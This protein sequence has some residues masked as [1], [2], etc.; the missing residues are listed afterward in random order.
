MSN[1]SHAN[2]ARVIHFRA[3]NSPRENSLTVLSKDPFERTGRE[4]AISG[5]KRLTGRL[6]EPRVGYVNM[7]VG[8]L[9]RTCVRWLRHI[10]EVDDPPPPPLPL[11]LLCSASSPFLHR[12]HRR[13]VFG[14]SVE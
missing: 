4:R 1:I 10:E 11:P 3:R 2:D 14:Y 12:A 13:C 8:V 6:A 9:A 5:R 7:N